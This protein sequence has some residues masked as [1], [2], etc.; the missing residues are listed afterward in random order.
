MKKHRYIKYSSIL[1]LC[2]IFAGCEK[3][4]FGAVKL[5]LDTNPELNFGYYRDGERMIRD[6]CVTDDE[7]VVLWQMDGKIFKYNKNG[8]LEEE[9][10]PD[11]KSSGLTA[12]RIACGK[13]RD[14]YLL[15]GHNNAVITVNGDKIKNVSQVMF[16][17]V[18]L[19]TSMYSGKDGRLVFSV[20]DIE[21]GAYTCGVDVSGKEAWIVGEK[22]PGYLI[23]ETTTFKPEL[24]YDEN[25][26]LENKIKITLYENGNVKKKFFVVSNSVDKISF[27]GM[28]F[29]GKSDGYYFGKAFEFISDDSEVMGESFK[30]TFL[31]I[32]P[33]NG[34]VNSVDC[35]MGAS[36][37]IR[38]F[39][40]ESYILNFFEKEVEIK[41]LSE[42]Y[43]M[44]KKDNKYKIE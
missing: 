43:K 9:Y 1:L 11:L 6:F 29:Y 19:I 5:S 10:E 17:D 21:N 28:T 4:E 40:G 33:D 18:G 26:V 15:D 34:F 20:N 36:E 14:M 25:R 13:E 37:V 24:I 2:F 3:E 31:Y 44:G 16:T 8:K 39:R 12:Y 27:A 42:I 41:K 32:N 23:D 38:T 30:E 35:D 22:L 7:K